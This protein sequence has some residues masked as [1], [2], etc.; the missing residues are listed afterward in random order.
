[1]QESLSPNYDSEFLHQSAVR[2]LCKWRADWGLAK[3]RL[4]LS[5][6]KVSEV[7][8]QDF[9]IQ[10]QLGNKGEYKCW[11]KPLSQQQDLGI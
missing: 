1:M 2:Q 6:H 3:F 11:K 5:K 10:W 9:Y 7:L 4:Y 8:L